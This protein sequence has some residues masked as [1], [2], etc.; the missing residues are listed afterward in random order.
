MIEDAPP[1]PVA[2]DEEPVAQSLRVLLAEDNETNQKL[3][4]RILEK[5]GHRV[6]LA[7]NGHEALAALEREPFDLVLMDVQMPQIDGLEATAIIR[8]LERGTGRHLPIVAMTAHA[9]A[10][11]WERCLKAGMDAY[12]P[13]PVDA[14]KLIELIKQAT[15]A[16]PGASGSRAGCFKGT[17]G[18]GRRPGRG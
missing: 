2:G 8:D 14:R 10:G 9:M 18:P 1:K 16:V 13:K 12:L 3:A 6:E 15:G 7:Q 11:D 5:H 4:V 17:A